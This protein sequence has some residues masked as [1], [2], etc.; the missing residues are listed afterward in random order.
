LTPFGGG[1]R[2]NPD[3]IARDCRREMNGGCARLF[4]LGLLVVAAALVGLVTSLI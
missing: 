3:E 2:F 1:P 4:G